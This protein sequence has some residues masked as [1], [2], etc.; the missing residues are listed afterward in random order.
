MEW[1][2]AN[3]LL[4]NLTKTVLMNFWDEDS[5]A[6]IKIDGIAIPTVKSTKFLGV[7]LDSDLTWSIHI[8]SVHKKLMTNKM[9]LSINSNMLT[10]DCLKSIYCAHIDSHLCYNLLAWGPMA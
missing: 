9:M 5:Q 10:I 3:Q 2:K 6:D 7:N 1:F 8:D 4:L